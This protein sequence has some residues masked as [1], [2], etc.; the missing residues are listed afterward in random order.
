MWPLPVTPNGNVLQN[1]SVLSQPVLCDVSGIKTEHVPS[2][3][4]I[5]YVAVVESH[6]LSSHP[7]PVHLPSPD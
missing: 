5:L 6:P 3:R 1:F 2:P 7:P 4:S